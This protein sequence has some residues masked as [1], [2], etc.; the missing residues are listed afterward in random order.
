MKESIT[1]HFQITIAPSVATSS[2]EM[3]RFKSRSTTYNSAMKKQTRTDMGLLLCAAFRHKYALAFLTREVMGAL[4]QCTT[5]RVRQYEA[6]A[7]RK[8]RRQ[9]TSEDWETLNEIFQVDRTTGI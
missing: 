6:Q 5:E 4:M 3:P 2:Q 8:I 1:A 9:M 7:L